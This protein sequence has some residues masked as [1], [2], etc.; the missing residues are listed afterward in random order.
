MDAMEVLIPTHGNFSIAVESDEG[1][2]QVAPL[3]ASKK[4][5]TRDSRLMD[6]GMYDKSLRSL[7]KESN[8]VGDDAP[9]FVTPQ[10]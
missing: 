4:S 9:K 10:R 8:G 6:F 5:K 7:C 2:G 3:P 1:L